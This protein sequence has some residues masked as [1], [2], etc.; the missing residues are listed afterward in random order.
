MIYEKFFFTETI[1]GSN[2]PDPNGSVVVDPEQAPVGTQ[3][4]TPGTVCARA[5]KTKLNTKSADIN[6]LCFLKFQNFINIIK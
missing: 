1:L 3:K 2:C 6:M 5:H 4:Q